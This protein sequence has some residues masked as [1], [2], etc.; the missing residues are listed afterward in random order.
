L[1]HKIYNE[2][3]KLLR[4]YKILNPEFDLKLIIENS[5]YNKKYLTL[6]ELNIQDINIKK[7]NRTISRRIA[8]EPLS[9]IFKRKE[10]WSLEFY[11]N[12]YVLDPRPESEFIIEGVIK[13]FKN[14]KKKLHICDFGTGSGCIIISLLTE[15]K[16]SIGMGVDISSNAIKVAKKNL[17]NYKL[18]DRLELVTSDWKNIKNK[19]DIIVSNPPYIK[20]NDYYNLDKEVKNYDPK[21]SLFGGKTGL[22]KIIELAPIV[23]RCM[24]KNSLFFLEIGYLQKIDIIKKLAAEKLILIDV[25][26]DLQGLERVLVFKK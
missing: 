24:K 4:S 22:S 5:C 2:N 26:K 13:Y 21:I 15:Y 3:L 8:G 7:L 10:F 12:N 11:I 1:I 19:Y 9:K 23:F 18:E 16:K 6:S 14:R 20:A 25:L 17:I